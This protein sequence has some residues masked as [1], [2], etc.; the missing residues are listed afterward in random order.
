MGTEQPA[1]VAGRRAVI[2]G[3]LKQRLHTQHEQREQQQ[4][5]DEQV[6]SLAH[7]KRPASLLE[8]WTVFD[9]SG[10]NT[11]VL[12][13]EHWDSSL[14]GEAAWMGANWSGLALYQDCEDCQSVLVDP[15]F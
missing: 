7:A 13:G 2:R 10:A 8:R 6:R 15:E 5:Y 14:L 11:T 9:K 1:T 12:D 3:E 4:E